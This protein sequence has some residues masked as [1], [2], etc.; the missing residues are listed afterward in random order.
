MSRQSLLQ[1]FRGLRAVILAAP[2]TCTDLLQTGLGRLG[3]VICS[4]AAQDQTWQ[5]NLSP[6]RDVLLVDADLGIDL[7]AAL[8]GIVQP[9]VA[10]IAL[11]GS[12][13]PSRLKALMELGATGVIRKPV[14]PG[15]LYSALYLGIN[16]FRARRELLTR[17]AEHERRRQGRRLLI[18]AIIRLMHERGMSDDAAYDFLRQESMRARMPLEH[19]C[20]RLMTAQTRTPERTETGKDIRDA[21]NFAA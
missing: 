9:P 16:Q 21:S 15:S 20:E 1:N 3:L 18:K 7:T 13:A 6:D 8:G 19:Y 5:T 2:S 11:T 10:V 4:V 14:H 12:D 17:L